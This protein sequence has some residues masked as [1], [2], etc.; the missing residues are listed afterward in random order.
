MG[1]LLWWPLRCVL[2]RKPPVIKEAMVL[3]MGSK[4]LMHM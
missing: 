4:S 2:E 3:R 1:N